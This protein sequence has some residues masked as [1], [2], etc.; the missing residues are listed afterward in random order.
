MNGIAIYPEKNLYWKMIIKEQAYL[1]FASNYQD[2]GL[3]S[4]ISLSNFLNN[5]SFLLESLHNG[6]V[7]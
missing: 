4:K 3:F 2:Y 1:P 6:S 5:I 7:P